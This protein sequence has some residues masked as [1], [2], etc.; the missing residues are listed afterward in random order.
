M[1]AASLWAGTQIE[2]FM[3]RWLGVCVRPRARSAGRGRATYRSAPITPERYQ[4]S[5]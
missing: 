1:L 5:R 2:T 4:K 3:V